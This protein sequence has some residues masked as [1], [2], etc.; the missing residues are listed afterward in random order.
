M[1]IHSSTRSSAIKEDINNKNENNKNLS[2][3][4]SPPLPYLIEQ[5]KQH[6]QFSFSPHNCIIDIVNQQTIQNSGKKRQHKKINELIPIRFIILGIS[7]FCSST[8]IAN[9]L[10]LNFTVICMNKEL[11]MLSD[12]EITFLQNSTDKIS[13]E[14]QEEILEPLFT[15]NEQSWLFSAIAIGQLIGTLPITK[16]YTQF[17]LR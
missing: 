16:I 1:S 5:Q 3:S 4:P 2:E 13:E 11:P 6:Q 14:N 8:L 10:A 9:P 17:G 7:L 15:S 12:E